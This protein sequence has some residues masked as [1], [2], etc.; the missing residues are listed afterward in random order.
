MG[1]LMKEVHKLVR[2]YDYQDLDPRYNDGMKY[3]LLRRT[4]YLSRY[5]KL[6]IGYP[7]YKWNGADVVNDL[8]SEGGSMSMAPLI[9]DLVTDKTP[10]F[11]DGTPCSNW[12]ASM[13]LRDI[14]KAEKRPV[15][16][17]TWFWMTFL[18]GG[19]NNKRQNSWF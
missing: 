6:I 17:R 9:H 11:A 14:L 12:K 8:V 19:K 2:G 3:M 18:F 16:K 1:A 5:N 15:R 4:T 10:C 13:I 7:G